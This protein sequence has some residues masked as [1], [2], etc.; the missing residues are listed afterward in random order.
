MTIIAEL[1][2]TQDIERVRTNHQ[3]VAD[4]L[5]QSGQ[6]LKT[7]GEIRTDPSSKIT[8][9]Y[10]AMRASVD[11]LI[12]ADG[13]RVPNKPGAH[14]TTI[15]YARARLEDVVPP[16]FFDKMSA[17]RQMR[18]NIEYPSPE[19]PGPSGPSGADAEQACQIAAVTIA[20]V[21]NRLTQPR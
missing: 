15:K 17:L 11:A 20:A 19:G 2:A 14:I 8:L 10:D 5:K 13:Y 6:T 9:A 16:E 3:F 12:N 21:R 4:R 1:L 18:H 7:A